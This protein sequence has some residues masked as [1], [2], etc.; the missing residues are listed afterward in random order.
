MSLALT[1]S[2]PYLREAINNATSKNILVFCSTA[3]SEKNTTKV[4]PAAYGEC[5]SIAC[6]ERARTAPEGS[7]DA[8]ATYQFQGQA[9]ATDEIC[10]IENGTPRRTVQSSSVATA[11]AAGV[12]SLTLA[13]GRYANDNQIIAPKMFIGDMFARMTGGDVNS[14]F[15]QPDKFFPTEVL[16]QEQGEEFIRKN[17]VEEKKGKRSQCW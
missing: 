2:S 1:E 16:D 3:D 13:C 10:Y 12:A 7:S 5:L 4:W 11:I 14:R 6:Q 9:F 17:F 8:K 15:I